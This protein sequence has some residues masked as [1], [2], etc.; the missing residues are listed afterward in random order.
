MSNR[1]LVSSRTDVAPTGPE[2]FRPAP[3]PAPR[4]PLALRVLSGLALLALLVGVPAVLVWLSGPP[5]IPTRLPTRED[6]SGQL[7]IEQVVTILVA[8]VW[9]AWLQFVSCV[10][11]EAFAAVRD[12]GIARALP[13]AGP[14]Q[15]LARM[16]VGG[17]LLSGVIAGQVAAVAAAVSADHVRATTTVSQSVAAAVESPQVTASTTSHAPTAATLPATSVVEHPEGPKVYTVAPPVGRHHD[18]L[19][20][21]AERH[22]GDGRRYHEI[23]A[24][25]QGRIQPDGRALHLAR[26]IQP[27]WQLVMPEDAVGVSRMPLQDLA[28]APGTAAEP[29]T[30]ASTTS[31]EQAPVGAVAPST[32]AAPTPTVAGGAT[33]LSLPGSAG[34]AE[35]AASST[36]ATTSSAASIT[37]PTSLGSLAAPANP[38]VAAFASGGTFAACLMAALIRQRR[39]NGGGGVAGADGQGVEVGLRAGADPD[40]LGFVDAALRALATDCAS[41]GLAVPHIVS[42]CADD[43]S[44]VIEVSPPREDAP[45]RWVVQDGGAR[46]EM[47]RAKLGR[48]AASGPAAYPA[49]ISLGRDAS[50]RDVF[51]DLEAAGG[52]IQVT[53]DVVVVGQVLTAIACQ[54]ATVPWSDGVTVSAFGLPREVQQIAA[55]QIT[56]VDEPGEVLARF[57]GRR[58]SQGQDVLTGRVVRP[59]DVLPE[60]L[61]AASPLEVDV[62]AGLAAVTAGVRRP[63]GFIGTG[64]LPGAAWSIH[65]DEAGMLTLAVLDIE[66]TAHRVVPRAFDALIDLFSAAAQEQPALGSEVVG[67]TAAGPAAALAPPPALEQ[68]DAMMQTSAARVGLLGALSVS[69]PGRLD[70]SQVPLAEEIVAFL[71]TQPV[72]VHS[73]V[74]AAAI[75]PRGVGQAVAAATIDRVRDWLGSDPDGSYRLV[76]DPNG[77]LRLSSSVGVDWQ[78]FCTLSARA[79]AA[80]STREEAELLRRALRQVRGPMFESSAPGRFSWLARTTLTRTVEQSVVAVAHRLVVLAEREPDPE[81]AAVAAALGLRMSPLSQLLWRDLVSAQHALH[82]REA[83]KGA[84]ADMVR[85]LDSAGVAMEGETEALIAHLSATEGASEA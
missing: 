27:G 20:E 47:Q 42:A 64:P 76:L 10:I 85:Q 66:V 48:A 35:T 26:L 55:E 46:W 49:L 62:A 38:F 60:Y 82:G 54:L 74:L 17:L 8:V 16:L 65:V 78:V 67:L 37:S 81:G 14:S 30:A 50:G 80:R 70:P 39:R 11:V 28:S 58:G 15:R 24:L 41:G 72:G 68:D 63:F 73:G 33:S 51:I 31:A 13:F 21:I 36:A 2:R 84:V 9:L 5:P 69:A 75:W 77:R 25:N 12:G 29:A 7:G 52:P 1:A 83:M 43:D 71:A 3:L 22:L 56:V 79:A 59:I 23:F 4:R 18:S 57:A 6:I 19:W 61:V 40:R 53:G 45:D 32:T 44:L 34:A